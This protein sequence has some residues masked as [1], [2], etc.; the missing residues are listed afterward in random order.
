MT[1]KP[2]EKDYWQTCPTT[3]ADAL[4]VTGCSHVALD[5]CAKD[6]TAAK[7]H[8]WIDEQANALEADW[9]DFIW[10]TEDKPMIWC[11]PPFSLKTEFL[12]RCAAMSDKLDLPVVVCIPLAITTDWWYTHVVHKASSIFVPNG[13]ICFINPETNEIQTSPREPTA[14]VVYGEYPN[15][16]REMLYNHYTRTP[17][18]LQNA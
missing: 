7:C 11:N 8:T 14:L 10:D 17:E 16:D 9:G 2:L 15:W 3:V 6:E 18:A 4:R 13:R 12:G 5:A 1:K